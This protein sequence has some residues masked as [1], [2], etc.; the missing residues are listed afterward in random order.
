M[1]NANCLDLVVL[2]I[3]CIYQFCSSFVHQYPPTPERSIDRRSPNPLN[4]Q[5]SIVDLRSQI[6]LFRTICSINRW[7]SHQL[8]YSR[9]LKN[10]RSSRSAAG[11]L[12]TEQQI[13]FSFLL[14]FTVALVHTHT[15]MLDV[16]LK[17]FILTGAS[18]FMG[19]MERVLYLINK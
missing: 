5:R 12:S 10:S 2:N 9:V 16:A 18:T 11:G 15:H 1:R 3:S 8:F 17:L 4:K 14:N 7:F 19:K 6:D 13:V